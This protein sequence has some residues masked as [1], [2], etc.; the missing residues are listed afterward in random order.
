MYPHLPF[1]P[2]LGV[3]VVFRRPSRATERHRTMLEPPNI[4]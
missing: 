2:F 1:P 4:I 3:P